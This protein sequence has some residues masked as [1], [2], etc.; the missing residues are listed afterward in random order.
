MGREFLQINECDMHRKISFH[1]FLFALYPVFSFWALNRL[2]VS[3]KDTW[4]TLVFCLATAGIVY[5][6]ASW[7]SRGRGKPALFSSLFVVT[8]FYFGQAYYSI[9][10]RIPYLGQP[11]FFFIFWLT[12]FLLGFY[13]IFRF[14]RQ[15]E[16][17]DRYLT[18]VSLILVVFPVWQLIWSPVWRPLVQHPIVSP[19]VSQ[20]ENI[21]LTGNQPDIY[22][23]ILDGYG[24]SDI[25]SDFFSLDN[26][27]F[28]DALHQRGFY[29]ADQ[30][31]TNYTQTLLSLTSSM[32]GNYL[33]M[34]RAD[35]KS[36][37]RTLIQ[38]YLDENS[39]IHRF[40]RMGY[41]TLTMT[42]SSPIDFNFADRDLS[43]N[44]RFNSFELGFQSLTVGR[45]WSRSTYEYVH[46]EVLRSEIDILQQLPFNPERPQFVF[47]HLLAPHPPFVFDASGNFAPQNS[48]MF[49]DGSHYKGTRDEYI[50]GYSLKV[51][52]LNTHL[53]N[54]VDHLLSDPNRPVV[55]ILQGDHG[56]G[57]YWDFESL[58]NSCLRE[59]LPIFNAYYFPH[60]NAREKLY[61]SISPV[62]SLRLIFDQILDQSMPL[63]DDCSFNSTWSYPYDFKD[64][65]GQKETCIPLP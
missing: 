47:A 2:S 11:V 27:N 50:R 8:F 52:Y 10:G 6:L 38:Q 1:P 29:V 15:C 43:V 60:E 26:S 12:F 13:L 20:E 37:D 57:S 22:Y 46:W 54:I 53:I 17:L 23:L 62:N 9:E 25:L 24:R 36:E 7:I 32:T 19:V 28:L 5:L 14:C 4:K 40:N 16:L 18:W 33:D 44:P 59:R 30:S 63:L 39:Y 58:E 61:P 35:P 48:F 64:V 42:G 34:A 31:N 21:D 56:S 49:G 51:Q 3:L 41:E 55:I 65:S 45:I